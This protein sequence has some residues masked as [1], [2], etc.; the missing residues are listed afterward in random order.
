MSAAAAPLISV[1]DDVTVVALVG[2]KYENLTERVVDELR[3]EL[4]DAAQKCSPPLMVVDL[5]QTKFFG[6]GFIEILF[7]V[8]NRLKNR[9]GKFAI[10]NL[11]EYCREV[12]HVTHL[13]SLWPVL[14]SRQNAIE[15]LKE[16]PS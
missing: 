2:P 6:S 13:D 11:T 14:E 8:A 5:A 16:C 1:Q 4:L 12:I 15:K 9:H 7:R 10:C 3:D